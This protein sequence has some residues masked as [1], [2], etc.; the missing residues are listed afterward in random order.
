MSLL[1][2]STLR[3]AQLFAMLMVF[4]TFASVSGSLFA[5]D[6]E[7][8]LNTLS[9]HDQVAVIVEFTDQAAGKDVARGFEPM[10]ANFD[11]GYLVLVLDSEDYDRLKASA[12][13]LGVT[14]KY[15]EATTERYIINAGLGSLQRSAKTTAGFDQL[16]KIGFDG[17]DYDSIP[18]FDCYRTVEGTYATGQAIANAFPNLATW[19][20]IGD[21]WEKTVGIGGYDIQVLSLTNSAVTGPKPA[22]VFTGGIHAR[23]YTPV[24]LLTTFAEN[25]VTNYGID[26]DI[27]WVLD[28]HI[29]HI[30]PIANPDGRK[31][32]ETGLLWRKNVNENYCGATSNSRGADLNRNFQYGWGCCGGSSASQCNQTYRGPFA[33]SEPETQAVQNFLFANFADNRGPGINDAA[34]TNTPGMYI[35]IHSSGQFVLWPWGF[36]AAAT[37][38]GTALQTLG[39]KLAFPTGY[40]P[41]QASSS[42]TTDG[43]T[44]SFG[45]GELGLASYTF[46]LGTEFFE[47]CSNFENIVRPDN[48]ETLMYAIKVARTPYITPAGP[49]ITNLA[50]EFANAVPAG[51]SLE[52]TAS[53]DDTQFNNSNGTEPTQAIAAA[54]YY[55][56]VP[57]WDV[58]ATP[59]VM[60]PTDGNFNSSI[61]TIVGDIDTTGLSE[62]RH[63]VFLRAQ[64]ANNTWGAVSA[65]FLDIDNTVSVPLTLFE[66][67]FESDQGWTTN[68]QS[69]DTATTGQWERGNPEQVI[70]QGAITQRGDSVS[71]VNNLVT[72]RLAGSGAGTF[73][74][75]SGVTSI[76]SPNIA[77]PANAESASLSLSQ[78][79]YHFSNSSTADFLRISIVGNS[80]STVFNELGAASVRPAV[81]SAFN[82]DISGFVGQTIYIL[83]EAADAGGG[84]LVEAGIDDV[85]V[86][87]VLPGASNEAPSVNAGPNQ[88][89]TLPDAA[90]LSGSSSDDGL[91]S[92]ALTT[93][94]SQ[95]SGPGTV[96]FANAS[97]TNTSADFS[98]DGTY[99]LRLT[100]DDGELSSSDDVVIT[101]EPEPPV[102]EAPTVSAGTNQNITLPSSASLVGSASDDGLPSNSLST[103]WSQVSG[104]GTASFTNANSVN[105]QVSF[106][107]DGDYVLRLT[108]S[109]TELSDSDDVVITV[110]PQPPVNQAPT[111]SAGSDQTITLPSSA[112]LVGS[113]SDDGLPSN[114]LST[115][116]TQVSGPG[117][118]N[119]ANANNVATTVSFSLDG[120][121]VLRLTASDGELSTSDDV[122]ITVNPQPPINQA[123]NVAAGADQTITLPAAANLAGSATDDG[124]P[125]NSLTTAWSQVSGPGTVSFA[126]AASTTTTAT[127]GTD[128]VYV[129]RLTANDGDLVSSDDIS[130]TVNPEPPV[131]QAPVVSAGADQS[132]TLPDSASLNG[133]ASDDGLPSSSLSTLWTQVSGPGTATFA[134]NSSPSTS[135]SFSADGT[136]V[137]RLTA[138]DTAL[139]SSDDVTVTVAAAPSSDN[140]ETITL[141]NVDNAWQTVTLQNSY[142]NAVVVCTPHYPSSSAPI[143]TRV[144]NVGSTSFELRAQ[145]PSNSAVV[146]NGVS[147]LVVE[148]G[149]WTLPD[150]RAIEAQTYLSTRTD[151]RGSW[152]GEAQSYVNSYNTPA[153]FGQVMSENDT[154]WSTFW[155]R[156]T[157][158]T[159]APSAGALFTGKEVAE[160]TD[161]TRANETIGFIVVE[162][163]S[164][165]VAG[166][167]YRVALGTDFI[168]GTTNTP[169][170]YDFSTPFS[171]TPVFAIATQAAMDGGNGGWAHLLGT[172]P[173]SAT[174]ITL[175][176]DEDQIR[177]S[178]RSHTTE[179]VSYFVLEGQISLTLNP[180]P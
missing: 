79:F 110:N 29:V 26:P 141:S 87:A 60:N 132:V 24:E 8:I 15:D 34:P 153:V 179:Q 89:V 83:I 47:S 175:A 144:R 55:I 177:D 20:D 117:S 61:E 102:N 166:Q 69:S 57:P 51:T 103:T 10:K 111:V 53:A 44:D 18:G 14:I 82:T 165:N 67:D 137:L 143:V 161:T 100:A 98:A 155:A 94:W 92:G 21:S 142:T 5:N 129:L 28:N 101:V 71:G 157:S 162:A 66:D 62:G 169:R 52:V 149:Q 93:N 64:D 107:A 16:A 41:E 76:R 48:F 30:I 74:I 170:S 114:N 65:I 1:P 180:S 97:A 75:D 126:N 121:Y 38:N 139:T 31:R 46:E 173:L 122:S 115:T 133:S 131:N 150:G 123:P 88:T 119:F 172:N 39:R 154:D 112:N 174:S 59:V 25:L 50:L 138:D 37:A 23:E 104:P 171:T 125:S 152:V 7:L 156:G 145:N 45:Y 99:T 164:G 32:A 108:A 95:V 77:I 135:V 163:G 42:F 118:A 151:R 72:G 11:E 136:Y 9:N 78:Y 13:H 159:A 158:R 106:S 36:Q 140:L 54:E 96:T 113:A 17:T 148:Q 49:D 116:W 86:S 80:T 68:P 134:S 127:F 35:D 130:I 33:A 109:D 176:V 105:T 4:I 90:T 3:H 84:S 73:D 2:I 40:S 160:D 81:W 70:L 6:D 168:T 178:E 85:V 43:E 128:G 22:I 91:P 124:L 27:T 147:C 19:S 58:A 146:A 167:D 12:A 120:V 56:D 63:T